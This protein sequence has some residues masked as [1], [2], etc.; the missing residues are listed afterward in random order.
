MGI[1]HAMDRLIRM[2]VVQKRAGEN[3]RCKR[4]D[5]I[6]CEQIPF[7]QVRNDSFK[8]GAG[9]VRHAGLL[10]AAGDA[11]EKLQHAV[12]VDAI[13]L[14]EHAKSASQ[15]FVGATLETVAELIEFVLSTPRA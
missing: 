14:T 9:A 6:E 12:R 4:I 5:F 2:L 15:C 11:V 10:A 8:R 1:A 7:A 3:T 13:R